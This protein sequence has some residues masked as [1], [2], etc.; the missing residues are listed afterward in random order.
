MENAEKV[1][2]GFRFMPPSLGAWIAK[3]IP[4]EPFSGEIPWAPLKKPINE[5]TF[6]LMT[7]AG[8]SMKTDSPFDMEREKREPHWGDPTC[9]KIPS[10]AGEADIDVNHLHI[11]TD[12]IKQDINVNLPLA[13]FKEFEQEGLIGRLADT[14]YS[15]YGFHL[16]YS[17][18]LL[19]E[20]VPEV[21]ANMKA[22][23]VE[24]ALLTPT[25]PY[26]SLS[27]G[28]VSRVIEESGISTIVLTMT[29][30]FTREVGIPRVAA[31]EYPY[32]RI[33][34]EVHDK[35]GQREVL[36]AALAFLEDAQE[37]GQVRNLPFTWPEEPK[38]TNWH[39]PE[40]SPIVKLYLDEIKAFSA[41]TRK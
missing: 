18:E 7:S 41:K 38:H 27:V 33:V 24:A 11:N 8:I 4:A 6:T 35:K 21:A 30:E 31:I 10:T 40:I 29:P 2:D 26:C 1:V 15:Y 25:R 5:T 17:K 12:Y 23:G 28:L 39:P 22:E 13:R 36:L 20:A 34:G 37:P 9:R 32:G 3:D 14:C 16:G 19:E